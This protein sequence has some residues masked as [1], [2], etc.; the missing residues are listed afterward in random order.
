MSAHQATPRKP[1]EFLD[2]T[3][4]GAAS[5]LSVLSPAD[6]YMRVRIGEALRDQFG[7]TAFDLFD[8]WYAQHDRYT[9]A[10]ST[11][12]WRSFGKGGGKPCTIGTLIWEARRAGWK[13]GK[14]HQ[15]QRT[16]EQRAQFEDERSARRVQLEAEAAAEAAEAADRAQAIWD[17][18]DV[19]PAGHGYLAR[20]GVRPHGVRRAREWVKEWID[21]ATG[22]VKLLRFQDPLLIPIWSAPG[23][24]SSLQAIFGTR[25]IGRGD[26]ARD[27]D[28]LAN[29]AKRGRY[30]LFGR[31]TKDTALVILCEGWATGASLHEATGLPVVVCFDAGNLEPVAAMMRVELPELRIVIAADNDRLTMRADGSAWNPGVECATKAAKAVDGAVAVP[32]FDDDEGKPTDFN[33]L[34]GRK[35]L[36]A[37]RAAICEALD[38]PAAPAADHVLPVWL[39]PD[40]AAADLQRA[41]FAADVLAMLRVD[42][43]LFQQ[44]DCRGVMFRVY[45]GLDGLR[46]ALEEVGRLLPGALLHVLIAPELP[47]EAMPVAQEAGASVEILQAGES[48]VDSLWSEVTALTGLRELEQ[49]VDAGAQ[50]LP[51]VGEVVDVQPKSEAKSPA[52]TVPATRGIALVNPQEIGAVENSDDALALQF[53]ECAAN[54]RWSP[55]LGWMIDNGVTWSRDDTMHR[56]DLARRM[57]RAVAAACDPKSESEAK[58]ISSAKSVAATLTLAQSDRRIVVPTSA[59]DAD[60]MLLNTPGGVVDLRTGK[61]RERGIEY[62]T[63]ATMVAP[64]FSVQCPTWLKF[65]HQVFLGEADMIEFMQ[66]SMGYWLSGSVREQ[67]IHFLHGQGSNGKSV[68]SDLVKWIVGSYGVKLT[69]TALMQSKGERHPTELAQLRG[70]RLALSSELGEYDYFNEALLKELTGD[71]T[72]SARFMRGDFFEFQMSQKHLIVGNF[73][74]R[75]RGGD[76]AIARRMLLVP[77]NATF[78]GAAKDMG[79]L[80]KL[81]AEAPAILAWMIQGAVKWHADGL[82]IPESVRAASAEY[83]ADNDDMGLWM[84]ECCEMTGEAKSKDL[85]DSFAAWKKARGEN[86]PSQTIW[87]GRMTAHAGITKRNSNG[88]IYSGIRLTA[89]EVGIQALPDEAWDGA[90]D[91]SPAHPRSGAYSE[92]R[93]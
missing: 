72:L 39:V 33:D 54:F 30:F 37:V 93:G 9:A 7:D 66:R 24:L 44:F 89:V 46:A 8:E 69:A 31:I 16:P 35:G 57:C 51:A 83:M 47:G 77:F 75:L 88:V 36:E 48:W 73:K 92:I 10:E 86:A 5:A 74:P 12:A 41:F 3:P 61:L 79:L 38:L 87:G 63:Q 65:M 23:K 32:Q 42:A 50:E 62:V 43:K 80:D 25:C 29:G 14:Q 64:G 18:A 52:P 34:H 40:T 27:K 26:D 11:Q 45:R 90:G 81:K 58:R 15:A 84:G 56:F 67:V 17:A 85:Y 60:P 78:K 6:R 70:K 59:W 68:L 4:E 20:K 1:R 91:A 49:S 55:G 13:P 2:L 21:P 82:A 76:P 53:V 28:Y 19:D 71:A 22:E